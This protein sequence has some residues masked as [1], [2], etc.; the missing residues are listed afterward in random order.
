MTVPKRCARCEKTGDLAC[1]QLLND[2]GDLEFA[3]A[4]KQDGTVEVP[5]ASETKLLRLL[6]FIGRAWLE[7]SFAVAM[8]PVLQAGGGMSNKKYAGMVE[9]GLLKLRYYG[10]MDGAVRE[11]MRAAGMKLDAGVALA[12]TQAA[13][14][15]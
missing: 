14:R 6:T 9:A 5:D 7:T 12:P 4:L 15:A 11:R 2:A 10:T 8:L 13:G 1:I 3:L